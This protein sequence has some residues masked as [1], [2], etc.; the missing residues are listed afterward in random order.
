MTSRSPVAIAAIAIALLLIFAG[1]FSI[2]PETK[3]A[4]I[5]RLGTPMRVVNRYH[6]DELFGRTG[7]GLIA[8][9]PL[10]DQIVW[11]DKRV[12]DFDV[13]RQELR[14]ADQVRLVVNS[15][16][17][18]RV[19]DPLKMWLTTGGERRLPDLLRP[20]MTTAL[21]NEFDKRSLAAIFG[22]DRDGAMAAVQ[23]A[24]NRFTH[25]YGIEVAD[26]RI[27]RADLPAGAPIDAAYERMR[28]ARGQQALAIRVGGDRQAQ[29]IRARA[30]ADTAKIYA[31]SFGQDPNFYAFYRAMKSYRLSFGADGSN[32]PGSTTMVLGPDNAYLRAFERKGE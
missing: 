16:A 14:T 11:I 10:V 2:V 15:Y 9:I 26:I 31:D 5:L 13:D 27:E 12:R 28:T 17:R 4:L 6:D 7:A 22:N 32:P 8:R 23:G 29:L 24:M 30:D 18:Y 1:T 21:R 20:V 3:Q 19:V 25:Q